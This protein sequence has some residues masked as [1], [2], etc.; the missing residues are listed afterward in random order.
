[1]SHID[2]VSIIRDQV[3]ERRPDIN[4]DFFSKSR[5]TRSNR[6]M[7]SS[8]RK[9]APIIKD[10]PMQVSTFSDQREEGKRKSPGNATFTFGDRRKTMPAR[11]SGKIND[12]VEVKRSLTPALHAI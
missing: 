1:M 3:H 6:Q 8:L 7:A 12:T 4:I 5:T 9:S 10:A 11:G 2:N